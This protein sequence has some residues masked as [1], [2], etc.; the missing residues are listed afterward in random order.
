MLVRIVSSKNPHKYRIILIDIGHDA[1]PDK[2]MG[3]V[4]GDWTHITNLALHWCKKFEY[5]TWKLGKTDE[6]NEV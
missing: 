6:D 1:K 3:A 2:D 4:E 5:Y